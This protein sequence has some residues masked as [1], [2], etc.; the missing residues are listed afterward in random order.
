MNYLILTA[1]MS[2]MIATPVAAQSPSTT[3]ESSEITS[4]E[5]EFL[6]KSKAP[7]GWLKF[8]RFISLNQESDARLTL[9]IANR[10][11]QEAIVIEDKDL[12]KAEKLLDEFNQEKSTLQTLTNSLTGDPNSSAQQF[13]ANYLTDSTEQLVALE[14]IK[15]A[16][17][18]NITKKI[19]HLKS[20]ATKD[21][22]KILANP[23]L[24]D[25]ERQEKVTKVIEHYAKKGRKLNNKLTRKLALKQRLDDETQDDHLEQELENA[26][27]SIIDEANK[28]LKTDELADF[29]DELQRIEGQQSLVVLQKLLA[30]VPDQAKSGVE[31]TISAIVAK[32]IEAFRQNP[33]KINELLDRHSGS[34]KVRTLILD[35]IKEGAIDENL[36]QEIEIL[37]AKPAER[38][39]KAKERKE[40]QAKKQLEKQKENKAGSEVKKE[41]KTE[42]PEPK[43]TK[44]PEI[45]PSTSKSPEL[46]SPELRSPEVKSSPSPEV[47]SSPSPSQSPKTGN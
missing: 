12:V 18:N 9:A 15:P 41:E 14:A 39:Q 44:S 1:I 10:K 37:K 6:V 43:E 20:A 40:E 21:I 3:K 30:A 33:N 17:S 4:S 29:A 11:L 5:P 42:S 2:L 47:K 8:R 35:R 26:E 46:K 45:K 34:E 23:E 19:A 22:S 27:D 38:V 31:T 32:N 24:S 7:I 36:K 25:S 13:L 16:A 28:K